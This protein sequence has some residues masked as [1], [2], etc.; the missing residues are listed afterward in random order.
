MIQ[1]T[2]VDTF[3]CLS[4]HYTWTITAEAPPPKQLEPTAKDRKDEER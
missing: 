4:C 2:G 1:R 3:L